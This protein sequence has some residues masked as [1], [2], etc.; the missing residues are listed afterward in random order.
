MYM[1]VKLLHIVVLAAI[2][3]RFEQSSYTAS[4]NVLMMDPG[5]C[6]VV[7]VPFER[8]FMVRIATVSGTATGT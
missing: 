3:V 7:D 1:Y 5:V 4:E 8:N 2:N 6:A